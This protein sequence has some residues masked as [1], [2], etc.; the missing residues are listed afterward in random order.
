MALFLFSFF[1]LV[2]NNLLEEV[3]DILRNATLLT[4][5]YDALL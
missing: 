2:N 3:P 5:L 4:R 1:R